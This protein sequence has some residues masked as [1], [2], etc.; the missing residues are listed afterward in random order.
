MSGFIRKSIS[1]AVPVTGSELTG[2][3]SLPRAL[4]RGG[5]LRIGYVVSRQCNRSMP[6]CDQFGRF[7]QRCDSIGLP[8]PLFD[9]SNPAADDHLRGSRVDGGWSALFAAQSSASGTTGGC[10]RAPRSAPALLSEAFYCSGLRP[11]DDL[12]SVPGER[13][14]ARSD[15]AMR[16]GRRRDRLTSAAGLSRPSAPANRRISACAERRTAPRDCA[17][18]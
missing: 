5:D 10:G 17:N 12:R 6:E 8:S 18:L 14:I 1:E 16:A 2:V 13:R 11:G 9:K 7:C 3:R 4:R 15:R